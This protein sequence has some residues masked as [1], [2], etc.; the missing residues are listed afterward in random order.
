LRQIISV[1]KEAK[2]VLK[3]PTG[4]D[5]FYSEL[6]VDFITNLSV[7]KKENPQFLMVITNK[8]LKSYTLKAITFIKAENCAKIFV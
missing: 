1:E 8:L 7:K 4:P 3:T 2:R 5:R 6:S